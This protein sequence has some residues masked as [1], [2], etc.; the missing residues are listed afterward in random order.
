MVVQLGLEA[1]LNTS[2]KHFC[3]FVE[4]FG[5][6]GGGKKEDFWGPLGEFVDAMLKVD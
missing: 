3:L 4:E 6:A 2:F 5:L 1:H